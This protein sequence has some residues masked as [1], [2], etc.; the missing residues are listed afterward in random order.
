MMIDR[1][2]EMNIMARLV[3]SM[4]LLLV[5]LVGPAQA[6]NVASLIKQLGAWSNDKAKKASDDLASMG[7]PV[8]SQVAKALSSKSRRRGRFAARTLRQIG[9]DAADAIPALLETLKDSD[10]LTREYTVEALAKMV[11]QAEQVLPALQQVIHDEDEDVRRQA[12][13]A[14]ARL[15]EALKSPAAQ[16]GKPAAAAAQQ[17]SPSSNPDP[18]KGAAALAAAPSERESLLEKLTAIVV[19]RVALIA[20]IPLG[21]F[22]LLYLYREPR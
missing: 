3:V 10:A 4:S 5:G 11:G 20:F 1:M 7:K 14:I 6:D 9:P 17:A 2:N 15:T 22:S 19:I 21:F 13:L 18:G 12:S 16:G 8:V